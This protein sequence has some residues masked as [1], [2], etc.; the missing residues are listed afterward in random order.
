V[1]T[2]F[3]EGDVTTDNE[4]GQFGTVMQGEQ[5]IEALGE[6][7]S[8]YE[9]VCMIAEKMGLLEK[10]TGGKSVEF[11]NRKNF[12][13]TGISKLISYEEFKKKGYF[14]VPTVTEWVNTAGRDE[15]IL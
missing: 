9:I 5:C 15:G 6:S 8:D 10:Y 12:E 11:W 2:K 13:Y 4:S 7:K 1:S 3:E 14:M